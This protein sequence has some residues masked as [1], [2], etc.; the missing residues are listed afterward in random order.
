MLFDQDYSIPVK[1]LLYKQ[2][3]E[4]N[5]WSKLTRPVQAKNIMIVI[6]YRKKIDRFKRPLSRLHAVILRMLI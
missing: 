3:G 2:N 4:M 1:M 6:S 5:D